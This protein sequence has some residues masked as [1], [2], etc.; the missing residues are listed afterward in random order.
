VVLDGIDHVGIVVADIEAA[1]PYFVE[2]LG[3]A[4][5]EQEVQPATGVRVAYLAAGATTLQL[6]Q[7]LRPG[8]IRDH[9]EERG[10]GLHHVCFAV[11]DIGDA[12]QRLAP[13]SDVDVV[14]AGRGRRA[15]FL[16]DPGHGMRIELT[17]IERPPSE[18]GA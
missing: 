9:L 6:V 18:V 8:P 10:E 14:V 7:P 17:E 13:G 11:A 5:L 1:L 4:L 12:V 3:L 16:P 15:C 2:R